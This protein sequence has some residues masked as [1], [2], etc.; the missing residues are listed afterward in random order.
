M[1]ELSPEES[2][3]VTVSDPPVW[4]DAA[5]MK[6]PFPDESVVAAR[7]EYDDRRESVAL[8]DVPPRSN[9]ATTIVSPELTGDGNVRLIVQA[10][11]TLHC[12]PVT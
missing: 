11:S 6:T 9:P 8:M 7:V 12:E 2:V 1:P 5:R 4:R 3:R 10:E